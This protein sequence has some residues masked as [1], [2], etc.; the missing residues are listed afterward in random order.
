MSPTCAGVEHAV[1]ELG[2]EHQVEIGI[3]AADLFVQR[4]AEEDRR[5]AG[6]EDTA[7]GG[8]A[9]FGG[10]AVAGDEA[11]AD[12][13]ARIAGDDVPF[14]WA[15]RGGGLGSAG[16]IEIVAVKPGEIVAG[17]EA[18]PRAIASGWPLLFR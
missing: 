18:K 5:L 15:S 3:D 4:A 9:A 7:P 2:V 17:G 1:E 14:G 10:D 11:E 6:V 16:K 8:G 13:C 12:R